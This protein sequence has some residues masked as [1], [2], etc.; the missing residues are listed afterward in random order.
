[1]NLCFVVVVAILTLI[2]KARKE[3][4]FLKVLKTKI[5]DRSLPCAHLIQ[6]NYELIMN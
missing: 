6:D 4:N 5:D 2:E 3:H 1:M